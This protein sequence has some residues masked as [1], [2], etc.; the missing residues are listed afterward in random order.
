MVLAGI[1]AL[2]ST[3]KLIELYVHEKVKERNG[4]RE[5]SETANHKKFKQDLGHEFDRTVGAK[6]NKLPFA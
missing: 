2:K 1:E 3:P 4:R 6:A 5:K